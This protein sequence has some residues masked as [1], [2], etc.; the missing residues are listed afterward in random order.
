MKHYA[1]L[2]LPPQVIK[3]YNEYM[4]HGLLNYDTLGFKT[5]AT[6]DLWSILFPDKKAMD[7]K[8][9]T[10]NRRNGDPLWSEGVL[11]TENG[12]EIAC[13]EVME[14]LDTKYEVTDDDGTYVVEI[15]EL[16]D[17]TERLFKDNHD[18]EDKLH[19]IKKSDDL[20]SV[21]YQI[22]KT[23]GNIQTAQL[24]AES[25]FRYVLKEP[26]PHGQT[27]TFSVERLSR[28]RN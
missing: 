21:T 16:N 11:F 24:D 7:I 14:R 2:F 25:M 19:E 5:Y 6:A 8:V 10:G 18:V 27:R 15:H 9:C 20:D 13:T 3:N 1:Y 12:C 17:A 23:N 28:P 26:L 22:H 4:K